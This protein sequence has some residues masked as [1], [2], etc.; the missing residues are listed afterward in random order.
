MGLASVFL[1]FVRAILLINLLQCL[2]IFLCCLFVSLDRISGSK[3]FLPIY[4]IGLTAVN[5]CVLIF[6]I[7]I[8]LP[9]FCDTNG[10]TREKMEKASVA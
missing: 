5:C 3:T 10:D 2:Q 1:L 8:L 9:F 7:Y 4:L 6:R